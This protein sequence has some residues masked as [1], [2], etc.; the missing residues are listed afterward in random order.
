[1]TRGRK[2]KPSK[3]RLLQG[4]AG[5]RP[6]N[7][8]EPKP[9]PTMPECPDEVKANPVALA[10][11][12]TL[13]PK[14][15]RAGILTELDGDALAAYCTE[16]SHYIEAE[17]FVREN[18]SVLVLRDDKGNVKWT[19]PTPQAA[20]AMKHLEKMRQLIVEF[21]MTP[22]SRT[23][24]HATPQEQKNATEEFLYGKS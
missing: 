12:N 19:Q 20:M 21:G 16:Y 9:E 5:H 15:H 11:W 7:T 17:T 24:I 1:M 13:A 4:K 6:I 23:R 2:P 3:L 18:G 14:L 10:K 8:T 22:S